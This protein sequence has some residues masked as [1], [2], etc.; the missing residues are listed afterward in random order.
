VD[1]RGITTEHLKHADQEL[2][3]LLVHIFNSILKNGM[4]TETIADAMDKKTPLYVVTLGGRKTFGGVTAE[5]TI[6]PN[7]KANVEID[8]E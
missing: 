2:L 8:P 7:C 6:F 5:K 3:D 1:I 4:V